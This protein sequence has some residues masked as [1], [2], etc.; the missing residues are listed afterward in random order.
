M[1]VMSITEALRE[2]SVPTIV[3]YKEGNIAD[4]VV[5]SI[6]KESIFMEALV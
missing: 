3:S 6:E 2:F 1:G 5:R 4:S